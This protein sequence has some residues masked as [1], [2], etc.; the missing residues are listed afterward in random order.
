MCLAQIGVW[1]WLNVLS[2][3]INLLFYIMEWQAIF[4][5]VSNMLRVLG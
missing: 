1:I 4:E 3:V 2:I 5:R